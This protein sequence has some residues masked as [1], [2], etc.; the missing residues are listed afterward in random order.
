VA[1]DE[2][3]IARTESL[4]RRVN[5]RIAQTARRFGA[6]DASFVCECA[7]IDC[8]TRVRATLAEYEE[9]RAAGARFLLAPGHERTDVERV[10]ENG[11][12]FTLVEKIA[13]RARRVAQE[14]DPRAQEA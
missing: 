2:E 6:Q 5:E 12:R 1:R 9:A 4:F 11:S 10:E 3:Q 13:P 14:L 8:T 7:D